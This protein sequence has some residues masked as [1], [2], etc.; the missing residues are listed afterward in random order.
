L[1][2]K[3]KKTV[4]HLGGAGIGWATDFAARFALGRHSLDRVLSSAV[5]RTRLVRHGGVELVFAV[6]NN[7]ANF[8][9]TTFS[10]KEPETLEWIDGIPERSTLWDIGANVGLYTCYAAKSRACRVFAF[11]PSVFNLELLAR[12]I[13]LNGLT[14]QAIIVPLPL[15]SALGISKLS[16]SSMEWG[17][18]LSTFGQEYGHDGRLLR[19]IFEVPMIGLSMT[20]AVELLKIPQPDYVKIDVDGIE[21]LILQG[22]RAILQ[23]VKGLLVEIND[24]FS[25][26]SETATRY[27][28]E[29]GLTLRAKA[30]SQL[31]EDG[32]FRGA[33]NQIWSRAGTVSPANKVVA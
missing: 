13:F 32:S 1:G 18:A 19:K 7:L 8:R 9:A 21:H 14:D 4:K 22:G 33:F 29:A 11:E 17:G 10:T 3:L 30:H 28:N 16:M 2:G 25:E 6:P 15:T 26:H 23:R 20:D 12:N 5:S 27:L 24:E 31:V